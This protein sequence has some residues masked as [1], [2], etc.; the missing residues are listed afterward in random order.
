MISKRLREKREWKYIR[1]ASVVVGII[2]IAAIIIGSFASQ[3]DGV[4]VKKEKKGPV[5]K[6]FT[7]KRLVRIPAEGFLGMFGG[8]LAG[9]A[10]YL[11]FP[12]WFFR[13]LFVLGVLVI[14][15]FKHFLIIAYILFWI[16]MPSIDFIP[17]DFDAVTGGWSR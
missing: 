6:E 3:D 17:V 5:V 7:E 1:I 9:F 11:S 15:D 14:D 10:Y 8:V 2:F 4:V 13:L 12:L 16:F